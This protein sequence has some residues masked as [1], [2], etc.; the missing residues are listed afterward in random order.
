MEPLHR[1]MSKRAAMV[2]L[3]AVIVLCL[4]ASGEVKDR[5]SLAAA[6]AAALIM[7]AV[8]WRSTKEFPGWK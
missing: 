2:L 5:Y 6:I 3:N 8:A 7:N 1:C 4:R